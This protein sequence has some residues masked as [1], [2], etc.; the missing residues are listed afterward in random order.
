MNN[1][2]CFKRNISLT[3]LIVFVACQLCPIYYFFLLLP[4]N[5]KCKYHG[6]YVHTHTHQ[7]RHNQ[8]PGPAHY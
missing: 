5:I 8:W 6:S 2:L 7:H 4:H 1:K 3:F